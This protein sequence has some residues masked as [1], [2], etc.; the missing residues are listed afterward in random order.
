MGTSKKAVDSLRAFTEVGATMALW[1]NKSTG[2]LFGGVS[3]D[4][5]SEETLESLFWNDLLVH[6]TRRPATI[7]LTSSP[8]AACSRLLIGMGIS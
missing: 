2:I 4:D 5:T 3:D 1:A 7:V 6:L 8:L